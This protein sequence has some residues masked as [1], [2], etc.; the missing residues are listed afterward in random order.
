MNNLLS[1]ED[2]CELLAQGHPDAFREL[3]NRYWKKVYNIALNYLKQPQEAEDLVQNIFIKLWLK[4]NTI[5]GVQHLDAY[6]RVVTRNE[7]VSWFR[8][9]QL[10]L[11][12]LDSN[13]PVS[14]DESQ[15]PHAMAVS[16][17]SAALISK[18]IEQLPPQRRQ[19]FKLSREQGLSYDQIASR[20]GIVRETVKKHIVRALSSIRQYLEVNK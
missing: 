13:I 1:E 18:A 7:I 19:V 17:E 15:L 6:L 20:T 3:Y 10:S 5:A 4:R 14:T 2:L 8:K 16:R 12:E 9:N 11:I